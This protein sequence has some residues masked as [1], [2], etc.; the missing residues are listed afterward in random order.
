MQ[1]GIQLIQQERGEQVYKHGFSL[2]ADADHY[3]KGELVQAAL[4]CMDQASKPET[5]PDRVEWPEG[6]GLLWEDKIRRKT[7]IGKLIVAGAFYMAEGQRLEISGLPENPH[8]RSQVEKIAQEIDNLL[9]VVAKAVQ[10]PLS[11]LFF[12]KCP[13]CG[14]PHAFG[15]AWKFNGDFQNPSLDGSIGWHGYIENQSRNC[16]SIIR[17]GKA[18]FDDGTELELLNITLNDLD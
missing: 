4:Y 15:P 5:Q 9:A 3:R 12:L 16:H 7:K 10:H 13:R 8:N 17:E 6:W 2:E 1:T 14:V 11:G 18:R